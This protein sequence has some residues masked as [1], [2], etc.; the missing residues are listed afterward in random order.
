[1]GRSRR[2]LIVLLA[3]SVF[4]N[5]YGL[6][7]MNHLYQ[8]IEGVKSDTVRL[9]DSLSSKISS[10]RM[11]IEDILAEQRW[12]SPVRVVSGDVSADYQSVDLSWQLKECPVNAEVTL[13]LRRKGQADFAPYI[14]ESTGGGGFKVNLQHEVQPNPSVSISF[15][16]KNQVSVDQILGQNSVYDYEYYVAM[17]DGKNLRSTQVSTL[18]I[19]QASSDLAAPISINLKSEDDHSSY[20]ITVHETPETIPHYR[21]QGVILSLYANGIKV[22]ETEFESG[23]TLSFQIEGSKRDVPVFQG[24]IEDIPDIIDEALLNLDYGNGKIEEVFIK[25][26]TFRP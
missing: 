3:A 15:T 18:S 12:M 10:V 21:L 26:L 1:M 6:L 22:L 14:A 19:Q 25:H 23:R 4:L 7:R 2:I 20:T 5:V 13:Y 16:V 9:E 8:L 17:N 11:D 24:K